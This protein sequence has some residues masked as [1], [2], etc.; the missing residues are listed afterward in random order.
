MILDLYEALL[1]IESGSKYRTTAQVLALLPCAEGK[2][3]PATYFLGN[4]PFRMET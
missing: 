1:R 4:P 2:T 3:K